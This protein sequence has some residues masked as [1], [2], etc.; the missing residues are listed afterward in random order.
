MG[1]RLIFIGIISIMGLVFS[2]IILKMYF[3]MKKRASDGKSLMEEAV[4]EQTNTEKMRFGEFLV[5]ASII[6]VA[7]LFGLHIMEKGG[8]GFSNL[9][10]AL[11]LPPV[12]AL[13]N[14]RKRTGR[15][16]F[17]CLVAAIFSL[18]I[19]MVYIIIGLPVKAPVF[20]INNTKI[21]MAHTT[22]ADIL[23][24]GFEI[25]VRQYEIPIRNY[26]ELLSSGIF[27]KY[28]ADRS[29]L[30]KKGFRRD[31]DS[32][33]NAPYLLV[34]DGVV[35][36]GIGLYGDKSKDVVLEDCI[37]IHLRLDEQSVS[38]ARENSI[39]YSLDD[40]DLLAPLKKTELQ[41]TFGKKL[42]LVPP[43]K[44]IDISQ[45]HYGIQWSTGSDHLFW[46]DYYAYIDFDERN[47]MTA[48]KISTE[49]ARDL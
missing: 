32:M 8:T 13:F 22:V 49:I 6:L 19:F 12:M 48:F 18:Y 20:R 31:N 7:V 43:S 40:I 45:L 28:S 24:D 1:G 38:K 30:V 42:W 3:Y 39:S 29:T 26:D 23:A 2:A 47:N 34:K 25:Y 5:Y 11:V 37:I 9:A 36:G 15:T 35:L 17:L 44:P 46:N 4:N 16:I 33:Y 41:K 27:K 10:T 21:S 14:A